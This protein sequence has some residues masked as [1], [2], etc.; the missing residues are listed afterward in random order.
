MPATI[1]AAANKINTADPYPATAQL[2][3]FILFYAL[4]GWSRKRIKAIASKGVILT[5]WIQ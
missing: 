4:R 5:Y 2:F 3:L 1:S